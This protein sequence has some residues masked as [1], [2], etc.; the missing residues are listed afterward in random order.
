MCCLVY[1]CTWEWGIKNVVCQLFVHSSV[2]RPII[3]GLNTDLSVIRPPLCYCY[4]CEV[5]EIWLSHLRQSYSAF[6]KPTALNTCRLTR[7]VHTFPAISSFHITVLWLQ[8]GRSLSQLFITVTQSGLSCL[9]QVLINDYSQLLKAF[10]R[11][12]FQ[13]WARIQTCTQKYQVSISA[14]TLPI[15]LLCL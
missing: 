9:Q 7:K 1:E 13:F 12:I 11:M 14:S 4:H 8:A 5:W 3:F 10:R 15:I 2:F 6:H